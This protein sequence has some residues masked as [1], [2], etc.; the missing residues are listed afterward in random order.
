[1]R[2]DSAPAGRGVEK[3]HTNLA[4]PGVKLGMCCGVL[5]V[6]DGKVGSILSGPGPP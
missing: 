1:M 3:I 6:R 2:V 4:C 5:C